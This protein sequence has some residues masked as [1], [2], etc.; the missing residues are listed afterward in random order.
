MVQG[1]I[2]ETDLML[3]EFNS[4]GE[5]VPTSA[6]ERAQFY[7]IANDYFVNSLSLRQLAEKYHISNTKNISLI[8]KW[9]AKEF[10]AGDK[11]VYFVALVESLQ[12]KIRRLE[13]EMELLPMS[14]VKSAR[15]RLAYYGEIRRIQMLLA[16][17]QGIITTVKIDKS[18]KK[19][20]V[21]MP[22]FG[23]TDKVQEVIELEDD[24]V[25]G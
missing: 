2:E 8:I 21:I 10:D 16:K 1:Q 13:Q 4:F 11:Q 19:L 12:A 5:L 18:K 23:K 22:N 15:V 20:K 24:A 25:E 9:A 3:G 6:K 14:D 17:A 7:T